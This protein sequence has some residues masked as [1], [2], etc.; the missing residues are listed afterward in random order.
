[1]ALPGL[2]A[3]L[4]DLEHPYP[5]G[6]VRPALGEGVQA[7]A[8]QYVLG[9]AAGR[10]LDHEILD[11]AGPGDDRGTEPAGPFGVHVRS[12]PPLVTGSGELEDR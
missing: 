3:G 11:E 2:G 5:P 10:L 6:Q 4:I 1:M 7:G 9:H 12:R 8:E